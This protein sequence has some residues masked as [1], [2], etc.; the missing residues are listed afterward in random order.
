MSV[1][2]GHTAPEFLATA[3]S[4]YW[5]TAEFGS[6][7]EDCG[8]K[9]PLIPVGPL[10]MSSRAEGLHLRALPEPYVNLS[11]HT[12]PVVRPLP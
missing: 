9:P 8:Q 4:R 7:R 6:N 3:Q 11:I 1:G 5:L 12:A 10:L 2:A